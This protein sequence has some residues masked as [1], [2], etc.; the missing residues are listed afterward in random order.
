MEHNMRKIGTWFVFGA[1]ALAPAGVPFGYVIAHEAHNAA[2]NDTTLNA[3]KADIQAMDDGEAKAK[4]TK[5]MQMAEEMMAKKDMQ[6]C[7]A[8]LH[9]AMEALEE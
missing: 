9:E 6:G 3:T 2:C 7:V 8:H 1:V 4:A 5:E